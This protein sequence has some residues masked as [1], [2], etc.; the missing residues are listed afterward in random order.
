MLLP[1]L[2]EYVGHNDFE[3]TYY[4]LHLV[5]QNIVN[6]KSINWKAFHDIYPKTGNEYEV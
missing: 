4:Y 6:N 3:T 5:P 1:Y 2:S